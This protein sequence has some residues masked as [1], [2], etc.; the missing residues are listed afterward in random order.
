MSTLLDLMAVPAEVRPPTYA[1][2]L[3]GAH[4]AA[5]DPRRVFSGDFFGFGSYSVQDFNELASRHAHRPNDV[6]SS[7]R[8]ATGPR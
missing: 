7:N 1:G 4:A 5:Q 2:S 6:W 8:A 3:L